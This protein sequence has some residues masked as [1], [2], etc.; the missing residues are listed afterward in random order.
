M[1]SGKGRR[2]LH[3]AVT[4]A[5][6]CA[7]AAA[8][9]AYGV[10]AA[11]AGPRAFPPEAISEP[12]SY[13]A[14][15]SYGLRGRFV[16]TE[17]ELTAAAVRAGET[18]GKNISAGKK[19]TG[20]ETG[21]E[22]E[23]EKEK[24][25]QSAD[26]SSETSSESAE[27]ASSAGTG[28]SQPEEQKAPET[29]SEATE[30]VYGAAQDYV[31]GKKF[32][33][34]RAVCMGDSITAGVQSGRDDISVTW[35]SVFSEITGAETENDGIGGSTV[36]SG[37]EDPMCGRAESMGSADAVFL[38]GGI[39]DWFFGAQCPAGDFYNDTARMYSSVKD[40]YPGA[41]VYVILPLTPACHMGVSDYSPL[42]D[43]RDAEKKLA[44]AYGFHVI[45]IAGQNVLRADDAETGKTYFSDSCHPNDTGYRVLGT[46]IAADALALRNGDALPGGGPDGNISPEPQPRTAAVP[47]A[48]DAAS[49]QSDAS[50]SAE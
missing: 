18:S 32:P 37:G 7:A 45:D 33:W 36:W 42:A 44:A 21:A 1:K 39:N 10:S 28:E 4:A 5:A 46:V 24:E 43:I 30:R 22:K 11:P 47:A 3:T 8:Y 50:S 25:K 27:E 40:R 23:K 20:Q 26:A 13:S 17:P 19:E 48:A 35:P 31:S 2:L 49:S 15:V 9:P 6:V 41:D 12:F 16:F 38:A 29:P 14:A 34:K